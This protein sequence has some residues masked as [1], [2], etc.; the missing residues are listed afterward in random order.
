MKYYVVFRGHNP[1]VYDDW[2]EVKEQVTGF[3]G[4]LYK[5]Y[6]SSEEAAEAYRNFTGSEDREELSRL[7]TGISGKNDHK[8]P[9]ESIIEKHPEIDPDAWAVDAA[10]SKNPGIME[11]RG[12]EIKTGQVIFQMGPFDDATNNI[13]E[14]LALVHAMA[15][16]TQK[17]EYHNIYTD[18]KTAL[19]WYRRRKINTTLQPTT[20]NRRVF[21]LLARASMWVNTHEFPK[22]VIK[23]DTDRWGEIPADYGRK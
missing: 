16:M 7:I 6:A 4:A 17:G 12:V 8:E 2:E 1:G 13:G 9:S 3:S 19:S 22:R 11:Y 14:Y 23:W 18:S 21:E 10:C 15:L 5:G 20:R